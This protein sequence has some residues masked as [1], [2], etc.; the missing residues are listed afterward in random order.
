MSGSAQFDTS[1]YLTNNADVVVA[2]SQGHFANAL[3]HFNQFGGKELRAPNASFNPS[4]YAINNSDVLNAVSTGVFANVFAHYQEF[5]E[6]E[7]R[8]PNTNLASFDSA[9]YLA[10]NA[11]VAAAVTAGSFSSALDHFIQFGQNENRTGSGVTETVNP[12]STF[13]LTTSID[14]GASF[15][16]TANGDTFD[17]GLQ[18]SGGVANQQTLNTLDQLDGGAGTDTLNITYN[19]AVTPLSI[20]N[21][22]NVTIT[23][24]DAG[25]EILNFVNVTGMTSLTSI[26]SQ[27][28]VSITNIAAI[29]AL[30]LQSQAVDVDIDFTNTVVS[31][32]ADSM[33][34]TVSG[35]TDG[36]V[37]IE[38]MET[39]NIVSEGSANTLDINDGAGTGLATVN[40][41]GSSNLTLND[42]TALEA[43][44]VTVNASTATGNVSI[45]AAT[46]AVHTLTG[47]SGNDTFI[48][49]ATYIGGATGATRDTIAGGDGTDELNITS[50][51]L[52][53]G[54]ANQA[55]ITSI[56]RIELSDA[57]SGT[58]NLTNFGSVSELQLTAGGAAAAGSITAATGTTLDI[59]ADLGD[60]A[61][62]FIVTGI[63]TDDTMTLDL[64][65]N[66]DFLGTT[67]AIDTFTGIETLTIS[68]STTGTHS[69]ADGIALSATAAAEKIVITGGA[70]ITF[71]AASTADEVD[72]SAVTGIVTT[73]GG[74]S[75][76]VN[77]K[78]GN[79]A[80]V[81]NGS[82][83]S[84]IITGNDGADDI[85]GGL[86]ADTII[87]TET[88]AAVD[89][90]IIDGGIT[91]DTVV[92]FTAG[93][94]GDQ[95][96]MDISNLNTISLLTAGETDTIAFFGAAGAAITDATAG[97][98][99]AV[100]TITGDTSTHATVLNATLIL[101]DGGST[102]FA[103]VGAA[104]DAMESSGGFTITHQSNVADDDTFLFGY[105]NSST[106]AVHIAAASFEAADNNSGGAAAIA[107]AALK[108]TD[109]VVLS[110]V[111]DVTTLTAANI[112]FV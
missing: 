69:F 93:T 62:A 40:V 51:R 43:E 73:T 68:G 52:V 110:G 2:I 7:N 78:G 64:A 6:T 35:N 37:T 65:T 89:E 97:A 32:T 83:S 95:I 28:A 103:N 60:E 19:T 80:D 18:T 90:V 27:A 91:V 14:S 63:N 82:G 44:V 94:G 54:T 3:D 46:A 5:G 77:L 66:V 85:T 33:T 12:G 101:I 99:N 55:N 87:L 81:L 71:G 24:A 88:T 56:E 31:G 42:T 59:D 79:K 47:G 15:T 108:G 105:E 92:G 36:D 17:A 30:K 45:N 96:D 4:Y 107:D 21:I 70:A 26:A 61:Y 86:G 49:G 20:T 67:G 29:P 72:A 22:E 8:A 111:T 25:T 41:S 13:A 57:L 102:T 106:G 74:F 75:G 76:A 23:D 100:A 10:A 98:T 50:A 38:G 9:G 39:I 104:V 109:L 112:D 11:D 1:Y 16:G 84:D 53:A 58:V 48:L 34:L